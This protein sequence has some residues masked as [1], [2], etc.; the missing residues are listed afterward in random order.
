MRT[1]IIDK[2]TDLF[3]NL[4]FKS[5]T[6][7]DIAHAMGISKKT[8]YV[9]FKNKSELVDATTMNLFDV[10]SDAVFNICDLQKNPIEEIYDIKR[11]VMDHLKNE[12]TS[13]QYQLQKYYPTTFETLRQKEFDMMQTCVTDNLNR[14]VNLGMY[15]KDIDV[16]FISRLYF[17]SLLAIRDNDLFP[18]KD[19]S[20]NSL[21]EHFYEYHLRGICTEKGLDVLFQ[22]INKNQS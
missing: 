17:S 5:V 18:L 16:D 9:H 6:M 14:G 22:F 20:L 4:G 15:R 3:L 19:S 21:L 8:I 11:L 7:D 10:I 2:A 1:Q 13:P 12:K